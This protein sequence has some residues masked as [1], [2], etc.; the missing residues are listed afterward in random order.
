MNVFGVVPI[1]LFIAWIYNITRFS[2]FIILIPS[3]SW[4]ISPLRYVELCWRGP[5]IELRFFDRCFLVGVS[6]CWILSEGD[7]G[8]ESLGRGRQRRRWG[9]RGGS[10]WF[11]C[12]SMP[13]LKDLCRLRQSSRLA[14]CFSNPCTMCKL[15]LHCPGSWRSFCKIHRIFSLSLHSIHCSKCMG[16]LLGRRSHWWWGQIQERKWM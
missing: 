1:I 3:W 10:C 12:R 9:R 5:R 11:C 16:G 2:K 8:G 6:T 7:L 4:C 14:F 13:K 15:F